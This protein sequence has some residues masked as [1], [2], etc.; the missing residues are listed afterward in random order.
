MCELVSTTST[1]EREARAKIEMLDLLF[2]PVVED[3]KA[4]LGDI[5]Q[6]LAARVAHGHRR[7][8]FVHAHVNRALRFFGSRRLFG[9]NTWL[10]VKR[11][12]WR[13]SARRGRQRQKH[14]NRCDQRGQAR[15]SR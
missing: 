10:R 12:G 5:E 15:Y 1:I 7:G 13:L 8:H 6:H 9:L 3:V 14:R 4:F 11:P 2:D